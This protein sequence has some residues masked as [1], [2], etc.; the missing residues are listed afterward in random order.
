MD[1]PRA[2]GV[3][4]HPTSL[5]DGRLDESAYRF[6]DWL[7]AAGQS[8]WQVL[9]L[10]PPDDDG[11]PYNASSAFAGW[12]GLLA[13]PDAPVATDEVE[14]FV[15]EHASWVGDW[16]AFA[17]EDAIAGQVRFQREWLA[18]RRY[19]AGRGVRLIGDLPIYVAP[20][21]ADHVSRPELFQEGVVAGVPPD[22]FSAT[23]Q[24]W[25]NPLYDWRTL[26]RT[27]FRWWIER[28]RRAFE[29]V[30]VAR[31][32][33][34]RGFVAYWAVPAGAP[35]AAFGRWRRGPGI[36]LFHAV[37]AELGALPLIA[38]D[39]GV[40]TPAVLRLRDALD[41]PGM[42]V[43][44]FAFDGDPANPHRVEN[45]RE[46]AVVYTGTHDNDTT[47]GWWRSLAEEERARTGL[48]PDEP[49]WDLLRLAW[50]S[51]ARLALVPLQDAL[52]L[53]S[54]ARMNLPGT[55][56]GNW[57][58]RLDASA[59]TDELAGRLRRETEA[60]GRLRP[61]DTGG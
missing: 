3:L 59:L 6:V 52:E 7:A 21:G 12:T 2:S 41:L 53:G 10:A 17:G 58:W 40:I 54:Q 14:R 50:S 46:Q 55:T 47:L 23:G 44:Q 35:T 20:G 48:D 27:G 31:I 60:A 61:T 26:R 38:E 11:S 36:A 4:L 5:P 18:L 51:P 39:L 25:G 42:H 57:D 45:H 49:S 19:A 29:L 43:L 22:A 15:A 8:W 56:R 32:D 28:F 34:F 30:D 24:L 16:A 13:E 1:L 33:H 9:P 37:E